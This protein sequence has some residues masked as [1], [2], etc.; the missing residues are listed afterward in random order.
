MKPQKI[1]A[2]LYPMALVALW[3]A[4]SI[5]FYIAFSVITVVGTVWALSAIFSLSYMFRFISNMEGR[6]SHLRLAVKDASMQQV[7]VL[8]SW[9]L[10]AV[11]LIALIQ[12]GHAEPL[13]G[14]TILAWVAITFHVVPVIITTV[15]FKRFAS[16][17]FH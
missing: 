15:R 4:N 3:K 9:A 11:Y 17:K 7:K 12:N 14:Y 8:F 5:L 1:L 10:G 6:H 2:L 16:G 13:S